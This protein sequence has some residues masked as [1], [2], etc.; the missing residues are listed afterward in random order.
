MTVNNSKTLSFGKQFSFTMITNDMLI[1]SRADQAGVNHIGLDFETLGK[2]ERQPGLAEWVSDH[3]LD[4]VKP[5]ADAV[6]NGFLFARTDPLHEGSK[7]QIENLLQHGVNSLMLPMF[8]SADEVS[9]FIDLVNGRAYISI[10]LETP[11]AL[12]RL[13]DIIKLSGIDEISLGLNDLYRAFGLKSHFEILTS[14]LMI[15][16]SEKVREHDIRF[17][18]GT[19]GKV[20]DANLPVPPDLIYA[21]YP[22]LGATSGRLFRFFLGENP[23]ELDLD[24]EVKLLRDRLTE[25]YEHGPQAWEEARQ[26][27]INL[28]KIWN[29]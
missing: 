22:R 19:L 26:D 17:G 14:D 29:E 24:L 21:Q 23:Y 6:H 4:E 2:R 20:R 12:V 5:V 25:W 13:D 11:P 28:F 9:Q 10:L 15:M 18:F 8:K 1:A 16:V 27:L 3:H 7:I